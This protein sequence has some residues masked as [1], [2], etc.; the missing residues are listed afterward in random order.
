M[1]EQ[2]GAFHYDD[3]QFEKQ[4]GYRE[5]RDMVILENGARYEGEWLK[6]SSVRQGLGI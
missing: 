3:H 2:L 6:G 5:R 1:R 4:L